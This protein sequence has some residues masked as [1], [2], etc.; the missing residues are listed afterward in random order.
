VNGITGFWVA[1]LAILGEQK[2]TRPHVPD[3]YFRMAEP[4]ESHKPQVT[5]PEGNQ[6]LNG[7]CPRCYQLLQIIAVRFRLADIDFTSTYPN[8]AMI[9]NP[10]LQKKTTIRLP[11]TAAT[12]AA[13]DDELIRCSQ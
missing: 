8:W 11:M 10:T 13:G 12:S 1:S 3:P 7:C 2:G 6:K 9:E 4:T 5:D